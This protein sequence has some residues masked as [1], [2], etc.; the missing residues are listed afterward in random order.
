MEISP[1][2]IL[3]VDESFPTDR[4]PFGEGDP[5]QCYN[6]RHGG[7]DGGTCGSLDLHLA[8][9]FPFYN[10]KGQTVCE[11]ERVKN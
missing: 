1:E 6:G 3:T 5:V 4:I 11:T 2:D 10:F 9:R 8:F 7:R